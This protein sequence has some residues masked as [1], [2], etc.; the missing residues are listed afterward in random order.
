M[1]YPIQCI[2]SNQFNNKNI[3]IPVAYSVKN[4][5]KREYGDYM[6]PDK[7]R[8]LSGFEKMNVNKITPI[9]VGII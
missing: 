6:T 1:I 5:L 8:G 9:T 3:T 7:R 4:Y 2:V